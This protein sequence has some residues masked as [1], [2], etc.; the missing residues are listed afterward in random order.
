M[1][2]IIEPAR[3]IPVIQDV[4]VLVLGGG[5]TGVCAALRAARLGARVAIVEMTN[6]FGGVATNGFVCVWHALTDTTYKRQIISGV[7]EEIIERLKCIPNG[8]TI[9]MPE[10]LD[11]AGFRDP[12][13]SFYHINTEELKIELDKMILDAGITPY[14]HTRYSAPYI[15]NGEL[16]AVIIENAS[17]RQAI[18]SKFFIDATADGFLGADVGMEIYYHDSIQPA[19]TG[20]RV[21]GWDKLYRPNKTLRTPESR[22]RIGGRAG[23][24]DLIPGVPDVRTWF[25]SQFAEDC[26]KADILTR[27]EMTGRAQVRE[28]MN[29]LRE[30]DP[31]GKEISLVSLSSIIGIRETRQLKCSYQLTAN[32]VSY[33][34]EFD[35]A[36]AYCAYPVD[37]HTPQKP[38]ILRY[39]DG[40]EKYTDPETNT[41]NYRRWR[42]DDGPYP[43]FWQ[44]PYRSLL[45]EKIGNLLICGRAIDT[46]KGAHGATRVMISLN[47][48]GEAA[49]VA[50]FEALNSGKTVQTIDIKSLRRRMKAGGSIVF[51]D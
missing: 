2:N 3:Q 44:I 40:V 33:G 45:P 16:R 14:L 21:Y 7:T 28:M 10:D 15:V 46:D 23:W 8:I 32:D 27:G 29:I 37:I 18:R 36:I 34:R 17:G 38:T 41:K 24:D 22:K 48:T 11:T 1:E 30:T 39:L 19:T 50:C 49:G 43:T 12:E 25:K 47:Q 51:N 5:C 42:E 9:K 31:H 6:A 35:D 4:D 13:Y 20:A 26:S